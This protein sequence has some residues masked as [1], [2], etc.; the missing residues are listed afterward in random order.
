MKMPSVVQIARVTPWGSLSITVND[1][2]EKYIN[3]D[4]LERRVE[5]YRDKLDVL[6]N[7]IHYERDKGLAYALALVN[8]MKEGKG[9]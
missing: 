1:N 6:E 7:N 2:G 8:E 5:I 4:E 9:G 3:A